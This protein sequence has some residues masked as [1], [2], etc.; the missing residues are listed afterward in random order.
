MEYGKYECK[1]LKWNFIFIFVQISQKPPNIRK[2]NAI[3][4]AI[5]ITLLLK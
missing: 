4:I 2:K 1:H 5:I 3:I